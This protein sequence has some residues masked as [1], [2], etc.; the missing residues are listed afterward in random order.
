MISWWGIE[1]RNRANHRQLIRSS[2][3]PSH[4]ALQWEGL[5]S[6]Q[7]LLRVQAEA[8]QSMQLLQVGGMIGVT[9]GELGIVGLR[10]GPKKVQPL[11]GGQRVTSA[12]HWKP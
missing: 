11:E 8:L 6:S 12:S 1:P 10:C 7:G 2:P 5:N 3:A 9:R 4:P